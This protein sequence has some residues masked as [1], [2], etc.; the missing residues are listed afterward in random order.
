M[1]QRLT[2]SNW[3]HKKSG[4]SP[5]GSPWDPRKLRPDG[6]SYFD[7]NRF[8]KIYITQISN[9]F[10]K[11]Y[12]RKLFSF[13]LATLSPFSLSPQKRPLNPCAVTYSTDVSM[14]SIGSNYRRRFG[15]SSRLTEE[16]HR[17][18]LKGRDQGRDTLNGSKREHPRGCFPR[19]R[20]VIPIGLFGND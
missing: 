5:R 16:S 14:E 9:S 18:L 8:Y 12:S 1:K 13:G 11:E 3:R 15:K 4:C 17:L 6:N 10:P 7:D 20:C 19:N 2:W